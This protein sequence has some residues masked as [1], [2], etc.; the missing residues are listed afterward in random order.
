MQAHT[1]PTARRLR[2]CL[3]T[4]TWLPDVNGVA[5]TL[6]YLV[7]GLMQRGHELVL[8]CPGRPAGEVQADPPGLT[9]VR[10]P[11]V[12]LPFYREVRLGLPVERRLGRLW[13]PSPPDVV[14]IATEGPLGAAALRAAERLGIPR[15]SAF[16]TNFHRYCRHYRLGLLARPV[17]AWLR[18]VHNRCHCTL[19]PTADL[20]RELAELGIGNARVLSRGVDVAL[21]DPR[22]RCPGLRR[23]WGAGPA[24]P[25]VLHVGRLAPEKNQ[26]LAV[27]AFHALR[28]RLPDARLV[29]VGDG[30]MAGTLKRR[31]PETL[32][33]GVQRGEALAAHYAS[34]DLF[35]FP[36]MTETFGNV[37]T[38]AMASGLPVLAFN[39]A[40][41]ALHLRDGVNGFTVVRGDKHAFLVAA[42]G[43]VADARAHW[44]V[45]GARAR[46]DMQ[47]LAW[48]RV[49]AR[50]EE[51]LMEAAA[52]GLS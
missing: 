19:V 40:A 49:Y 33:A 21:F 5:M 50:L 10:V 30:P 35:L 8:V 36:S 9:V 23:S 20:A 17:A 37:T 42:S 41:A 32:L 44:T 25:V 46:Q 31:H 38:E 3:V 26:E 27:R 12:S 34:A 39:R 6:G 24:T 14:H 48:D 22:R 11:G 45:L 1:L 28:T 43:R 18:H 15:V 7:R 47:P 52:G 16:H 13:A 4:E 51:L 2:I 29:M